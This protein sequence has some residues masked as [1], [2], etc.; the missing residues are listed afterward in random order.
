MRGMTLRKYGCVQYFSKSHPRQQNF[1]QRV[2]NNSH[3][4]SFFLP[5]MRKSI[6][7]L[8]LG[9]LFC[10]TIALSLELDGDV[11][12]LFAAQEE[13]TGLQMAVQDLTKV[14]FPPI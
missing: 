4:C 14:S 11:L 10:A 3:H 9:L 7:S 12:W 2:G 5:R 1:P 8:F 13:S 6:V